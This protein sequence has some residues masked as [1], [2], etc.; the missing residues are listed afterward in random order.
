MEPLT[1]ESDVIDPH[2]DS[3]EF[4]RPLALDAACV[5]CVLLYNTYNR[6]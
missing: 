3:N 2:E 6:T 4:Y 1:L 5:T